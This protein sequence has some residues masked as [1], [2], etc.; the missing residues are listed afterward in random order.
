MDSD[1]LLKSLD[2]LSP[3][4]G[5]SPSF[6]RQTFNIVV[7]LKQ[8]KFAL[9]SVG[10]FWIKINENAARPDDKTHVRNTNF[11]TGSLSTINPKRG[12]EKRAKVDKYV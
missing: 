11:F 1:S 3:H 10:N 4:S 8:L 2:K 7:V 5:N 6:F 9:V 12:L